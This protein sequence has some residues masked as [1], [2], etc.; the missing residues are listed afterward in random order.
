MADGELL[1]VNRGCAI[2]LAELD[3]RFSASGGPGGQHANTANTKVEVRFD[4]ASSPSL[5]AHHRQ[6]LL[7]RLG[8]VVRV[9]ADDERSQHRNRQLAL[10]RLRSRL[11]DGLRRETPRLATRPSRAAKE[12]RL[13]RKRQ[14]GEKKR[15]RQRDRR[16][17]PE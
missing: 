8:P 7:E 14:H 16:L 4:V 3:W 6:R 12:R 2:P 5:S 1:R 15:R 10:D 13:Q 11:A 9:T 17:D